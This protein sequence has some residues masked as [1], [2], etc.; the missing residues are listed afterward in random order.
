MEV[1]RPTKASLHLFLNW[2]LHSSL[3]GESG[4]VAA[5][6][7]FTDSKE[8]SFLKLH[9]CEVRKYLTS[10]TGSFYLQGVCVCVFLSLAHDD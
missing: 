8:K 2:G 3:R 5:D 9:L 10:L 6:T 1:G 4:E 7:E